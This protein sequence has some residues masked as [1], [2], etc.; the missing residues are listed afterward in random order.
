MLWLCIFNTSKALDPVT[1]PS[2]PWANVEKFWQF[3]QLYGDYQ[4]TP[5]GRRR[6]FVIDRE[7]ARRRAEACSP[8]Q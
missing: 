1:G 4:A 7:Q 5:P 6:Q 8:M 3:C 2:S